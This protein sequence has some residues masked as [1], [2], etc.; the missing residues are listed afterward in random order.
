MKKIILFSLLTLLFCLSSNASDTKKAQWV[1]HPGD[2]EIWLHKKL[3]FQRTERN[4]VLVP[5]WRIDNPYTELRF[6]KT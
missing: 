6:F 5:A 2:F 1:Y 4:Q 3:T